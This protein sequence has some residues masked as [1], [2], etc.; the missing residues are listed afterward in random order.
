MKFKG[1]R[2]VVI[3]GSSGMGLAT[4]IAAA[5]EGAHVIIASRSQEKLNRAKAR[6]EGSVETR[7]INVMDEASVKD[8]FAGLDTFDHLTTPGNEAVMGPFLELD[9]KAARL[10]F[11]SK[12]WGQY[13]AA[14]YA[15]PKMSAAGS[16]TLFAGIWSQRPPAGASVIAA[17]NSAIEGLAR[18]LAGELAPIRVNAV[19]PG[20]VDTPIYDRMAPGAK[21][22]MFQQAAAA[23]PAKRIAQPGEI[24]QTVLYLMGSGYTT[25]STLYVDGGA[26]LR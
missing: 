6:I 16:I 20:I 1:Q 5:A 2:I 3:G 23:I 11:D 14:R 12:F 4:A 8:F 9:T 7:T 19:S 10:G 26:T 18:A 17:I 24:A 25:G 21:E 15:A 13:L 22:A